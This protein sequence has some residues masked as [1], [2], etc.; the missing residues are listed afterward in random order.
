MISSKHIK[1][2]L[3]LILLPF[4]VGAYIENNSGT[5]VGTLDGQFSVNEM[6]AAVYSVPINLFPSGT[7]FDPQIGIVYNSQLSGYGNVGYGVNITGL[8]SITRA[9]KDLFHDKKVEKIKYSKGDTYLLD[10][11]R[12]ILKSGTYGYNNAT[13]T[14]EGNPYVTVKQ[15]GDDERSTT[16]FI[17][18]DANGTTYEYR[19]THLVPIGNDIRTIAWYIS[20]ATNKYGDCIEY[21]YMTDN[22]VLYPSE[23]TY[24]RNGERHKVCF[25]YAAL[26]KAEKF[27][28]EGGWDGYINWRLTRIT[29]YNGDSFYRR[30]D[31]TYN[32]SSNKPEDDSARK[33]DRLTSISVYNNA[34]EALEPLTFNWKHLK[35]ASMVSSNCSV[36]TFSRYFDN[37]GN[38]NNTQYDDDDDIGTLTSADLNGDGISDIVRISGGQHK[39]GTGRQYTFVYVCRSKIDAQGKVTYPDTLRYDLPAAFTMRDLWNRV[40]STNSLNGGCSADI[41][42]DGLNDFVMPFYENNKNYSGA[43]LS[44]YYILG[45]N[46]VKKKTNWKPTENIVQ[47]IL[48]TKGDYAPH[49]VMDFDGDG[50]ADIL[51]VEDKRY[52]SVYFGKIVTDIC[53][54][55]KSQEIRF[56]YPDNKTIKRMYSADC[57]ADGFADVILIFDNGY[58]IYYNN[59]VSYLSGVFSESNSKTMQN[60]ELKDYWRM[61]QGDFNNDGLVDFVVIAAGKSKLSFLCNNGNGTFSITG[62]TDVDFSENTDSS[63]D[64]KYFTIRVV[65]F[66]KDGRSDVFVSKKQLKLGEGLSFSHYYRMDKTQVRLFRS[67]PPSS[68]VLSNDY[69]PVLWQKFDKADKERDCAEAYIFT[70]DFDGDGYA[71]IANYGSPLNKANDNT[72]LK[73]NI[74]IYKFPT[75]VSLGRISSIKNGF[76]KTTTITYSVGTDSKVYEAGDRQKDAYPVN[77]YSMPLPLVSKVVQTNGAA[78]SCTV[79]YKYGGLKAHIG[80]RGMLGFTKTTMV[81][82][83]TN[84]TTENKIDDWHESRWIPKT[85]CSKTTIDSKTSTSTTTTAIESVGNNYFSYPSQ[86]VATDMYGHKTERLC[87]YNLNYG[88]PS[89]ETV[90]YDDDK[91]MYKKTTYSDF[92]SRGVQHLPTVVKNEQRY[93]SSTQPYHID[94]KMTYWDKGEVSSVT[95]TMYE[96]GGASVVLTTQ[97]GIDEYGHVISELTKGNSVTEVTKKSDYD[98]KKLRVVKKYTSPS[99]SVIT[100]DYDAWNRVSAMKDESNASNILTTTYT[101]DKWGNLTKTINPDGSYTSVT[102]AWD[103]TPT[104]DGSTYGS[105]YKTVTTATA[106]APITVYYDSEGREVNSSTIGLNGVNIS[107][108]THYDSKGNVAHVVNTTGKLETSSTMSYDAFG[109]LTSQKNSDGSSIENSYNDRTV[110]VK[111]PTGNTTRTYDAWGNIKTTVDPMNVKVTYTYL[112]NGKPSSIITQASNVSSFVLMKY[113]GAGNKI[114]M[115]DCDA[116]VMKY[117][118]AADG[119]ILSETDA[120]GVTTTYTYDNI[121]RLIKKVYKDKTGSSMTDNFEYCKGTYLFSLAKQSRGQISK[122]YEYDIYGRVT[123]V[124]AVKG[125][126]EYTTSYTY[127]DKGQK[128]EVTYPGNMVFK[129]TYDSDGFLSEILYN[130]TKPVYSIISYDGLTMKYSTVAGVMEK[131]IDKDGYP[132]EYILHGKDSQEFTYDK[133]TGNLMSRFWQN[134]SEVMLD[135]TFKYDKLDRL[136]SVYSGGKTILSMDYHPN[137]NIWEK[138]DVGFY[139]YGDADKRHALTRITDYRKKD[140]VKLVRTTFGLNGKISSISMS[141]YG[142]RTYSYG[143][144]NEK[145]SSVDD[146][147]TGQHVYLDDY[148]KITKNNV[149]TEYYF[150]ENDVIVTKKTGTSGSSSI[151]LYQA[152]TDNLGS[153]LAVYGETNNLVFKAKYDVWGKQTVYKNALGLYRGYTGH[154]MLPG[155]ELINMGG[156]MYDPVVARFLSCD[157][158]VQ[159]PTNSQNFNRYS[160]CLNNPLKYTDPS[161]E[162]FGIDD[163]TLMFAAFNLCSSVLT[164]AAQGQNVWKAA[165]MSILTSAVSYGLGSI[166]SSATNAIGNCFGHGTGSW[167]TE[168]ARA[169]AHGLVNGTSAAVSNVIAGNGFSG[170]GSG[171]A[172][173]FVSSLAGSGVGAIGWSSEAVKSTMFMTGGLTAEF[174]GRDFITGALEGYSIG[175]LNHTWTTDGISYSNEDDSRYTATGQL[176]EFIIKWAGRINSQLG[177][178]ASATVHGLGKQLSK[179]KNYVTEDMDGNILNS[180]KPTVKY[181]PCYLSYKT[182]STISKRAKIAG[183]VSGV[184]TGVIDLV[185]LGI[186]GELKPSYI[187]DGLLIGAGFVTGGWVVGVGYVIGDRIYQHYHN[188][189]SIGESLDQYIGTI[190]IIK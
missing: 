60:S 7:G 118:Y 181:G 132:S 122:S 153:I 185:D 125:Q 90:Y 170:F 167:A 89:E 40:T 15:I 140:D 115:F 48:K 74:N 176:P 28:F 187:V 99:S 16:S 75:D 104:K 163:A 81:N 138:S 109:R 86:V 134:G 97:Y 101:Y 107:K 62:S 148:E 35:A 150:L 63:K 136:T 24:G 26:S 92:V 55:R 158:F 121:G 45:K 179:I 71:E 42:G 146:G 178:A 32:N 162:L 164:A 65:D 84:S 151:K 14:V 44:F 36:N 157:N 72:F 135:E 34:N 152:V 114:E 69:R 76:G 85:V 126:K 3:V 50:K 116:G 87:K 119:T 80:G 156:R 172:T 113:D 91:N 56:T 129:Y 189:Q 10:G 5:S 120:R 98:A 1:L 154:E 41:D 108:V 133:N 78:G 73:N 139:D 100:Y 18:T 183:K 128:S 9:G 88:L 70:G 68:N 166:K 106:Q 12:L 171:L 11:K 25:I 43:I 93:S 155:F 161:G 51:Y 94:K 30:Y 13:Y 54:S 112:S 102:T 17:Y 58:K 142:Y 141:D 46:I 8:S 165:G 29:S 110:T 143:P 95:T 190:K 159:E 19:E 47:H 39:D 182:I 79:S 2:L 49:L 22:R 180:A 145:I 124:T 111:T 21:K 168:L 188:G 4:K 20:K 64:D 123:K 31:F 117:T 173:G 52:N 103:T 160:Y 131:T 23:I 59:G 169:G 37:N 57:N 66:D 184:A 144:D 175:A 33:F 83:V 27:H 38:N 82:S 53:G 105:V 96:K 177:A 186:N 130:K 174:T 149:T 137:G 127:N 77:T 61:E 6:G 67:E 147:N